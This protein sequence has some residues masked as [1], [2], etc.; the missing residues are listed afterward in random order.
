MEKENNIYENFWGIINTIPQ[1][2]LFI[3]DKE[4]LE[5]ALCNIETVLFALNQY[6]KEFVNANIS[7][8]EFK[9]ILVEIVNSE[10]FQLVVSDKKG[11]EISDDEKMML[12]NVVIDKFNK[13]QTENFASEFYRVMASA[14]TMILNMVHPNNSIMKIDQNMMPTELGV[15]DPNKIDQFVN[16]PEN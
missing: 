16:Q 15:F 5:N 7:L 9:Q 13:N 12:N 3:K 6:S 14:R 2:Y 11:N 8:E 1:S 4:E 10:T